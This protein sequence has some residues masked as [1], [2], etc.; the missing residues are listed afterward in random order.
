MNKKKILIL[1][2][3]CNL[4]IELSKI[5][6]KHNWNLILVSRDYKKNL[7]LKN[8]LEKEF[9]NIEIFNHQLDILDI[10][11]QNNVFSQIQKPIDG[12]IS[13]IGQTHNVQN[14]KDE[15][16]INVINTNYT[17]LINF[18]TFFLKDFEL[19]NNG[20]IICLSSVAGLRGRGKNFFYGSAKSGLN[21]YLSGVRSFYKN[22]NLFF[23]TV[24]PGFIKNKDSNISKIES[25]FAITPSDLAK[26]IFYAQQ[27][28]K[29]ILYSNIFWIFVMSII[30][31]LPNKI[32]K[33]FF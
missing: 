8:N 3:T 1:G 27:K 29:E 11:N 23:M 24:L 19:R 4:G 31:V 30:R 10:Q 17:Y 22:S 12:V 18:L 9:D 32:F 28:K 7:E 15:N 26:K 25:L 2:A 13:L 33:K 6:A 16:L 14:I 20:F 21:T 5:Y